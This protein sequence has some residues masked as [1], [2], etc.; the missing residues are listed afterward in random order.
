MTG[1][2][3][4]DGTL[5][6]FDSIRISP[7]DLGLLG[8]DG[9]FETLLGHN[10]V[11][12]DVDAHL[13]RLERGLTRIELPLGESLGE[14]AEAAEKVA[15][16]APRPHAR[17]RITVTRGVPGR[18]ATRLVTAAPYTRPTMAE[19]SAGI[20]A[21]TL[22]DPPIA[23]GGFLRG[24][25]STSYQF[26]SMAHRRARSRGAEEAILLDS[27]GRVVEGSR[28]NVLVRFGAEVVTPPEGDGCL[29]GTVR[30][31]LM[32][33]GLVDERSIPAGALR[34]ADEVMVTNSLIGVLGV[35]SIDERELP[36][37]EAAVRLAAYWEE[38]WMGSQ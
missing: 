20:R 17:I 14:L 21:A 26:Y 30:R 23:A 33:A 6:P 15:A 37:R 8:G 28:S 16:A 7:A 9:V 24:V 4:H 34:E 13:E 3:Y 2:A 35:G 1:L 32:E 10:G 19:R 31:R 36:D 12:V 11:L 5:L 38:N 18:A 25:K 27:T 22:D 29:P